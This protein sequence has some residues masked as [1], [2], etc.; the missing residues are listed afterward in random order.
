MILNPSNTPSRQIFVLPSGRAIK[1][2]ISL[3]GDDAVG[4]LP[5]IVTASDFFDNL[6]LFSSGKEADHITK[7]LLLHQAYAECDKDSKLGFEKEFLRFLSY[8][9]FLDGFFSELNGELVEFDSI[10]F[11]DT[12]A[13]Y[14]E[15][16]MILRRI[17]ERYCELLGEHDLYDRKYIH[18]DSINDLFLSSFEEVHFYIDG[19]PTNTELQ[20]LRHISGTKAVKLFFYKNRFTDK[21]V[22]KLQR[23]DLIVPEA[24]GFYCVNLASKEVAQIEAEPSLKPVVSAGF[25]ERVHQAGFVFYMIDQF[26]SSG[27]SPEEICVVLPDESFAATL[28]ALDK[29]QNLNFAM[30]TPLSSTLFFAKLS[31]ARDVICKNDVEAQQKLTALGFSDPLQEHASLESLL[32]KLLVNESDEMKQIIKDELYI[33]NQ[34]RQRHYFDDKSALWLFVSSLGSKALSHVDGGKVTVIGTLESRSTAFAAVIVVDFNEGKVPK[35]SDKDLFL[36]AKIRSGCGLPS[37][38]DRDDLQY[39]Y[40]ARIFESAKVSALSYVKNERE[41]PSEMLRFIK[42][43]ESS[44]GDDEAMYV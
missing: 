2:S 44:V 17:S 1:N 14:D 12:Y 4:F 38:L 10:E 34:S 31:A 15:H 26:V 29:K 41:S 37:S 16:L 33:L 20:A 27:I 8:S 25:S 23:L 7:K 13:E 24:N 42:Q 39:Y 32:E 36:N 21:L 28:R 22:Q 9:D 30:G 5:R 40:Y 19:Y 18:H 3:L 11:S 35:P 6:L 43:E